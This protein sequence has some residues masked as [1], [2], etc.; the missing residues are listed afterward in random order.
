MIQVVDNVLDQEDFFKL[1]SMILGP[2]MPWYYMSGISVPPFIRKKITDPNAVE[3]DACHFLLLDRENKRMC[4]EYNSFAPYLIKIINKL[5]YTEEN[6][7]RVRVA[8]KWPK[9]GIGIE[10]YNIPHVDA[11]KPH[12]TLIYYLND[13]DGD[14]R[15]FDQ[16]QPP[17]NPNSATFNLDSSEEELDL[18]ANNF[19]T[20]GFTIKQLVTPKANRFVYFDG[21]QYHTAGVPVKTERRVILNINIIE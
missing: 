5:G 16:I 6:L 20:S 7:Y 11:T 19:I 10:K 12:K 8:M 1:Q 9:P 14:T 21:M 15:I 2:N 17:L 18:Y 4:Q 3:T 13:S